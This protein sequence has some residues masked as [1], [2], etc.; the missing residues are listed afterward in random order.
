[1]SD[2]DELK[3]Q[4]FEGLME[5]AGKVYILARSS[6]DVVIGKR[7]FVGDEKEQGITLVFNQRMKYIWDDVGIK[8]TLVFGSSAE[9]CEVP[10]SQIVAV[11]SPELGVQFIADPS[12]EKDR[13]GGAAP[14]A[15]DGD[16]KVIRVDFK[17]K[18]S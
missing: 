6:E 14:A 18:D 11:F 8:A 9:K 7:G 16:G 15:L 4:V 17:K 12:G 10:T 1:M 5:L 3:K 2:L 13:D